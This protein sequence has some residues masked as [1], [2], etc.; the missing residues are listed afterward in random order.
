MYEWMFF[1]HLAGLA[2]WFG[3]TLMGVLML[4]SARKSLAETGVSSIAQ[5]TI[6]NINR[7]SHPSS[8][9]V[10]ASGLYMILQ[11]DRDGLPF[12]ISFMEQAGGT[13]ILLFIVVMSILGSKLRKKLAQAEPAVAARSIGSYAA[14]TS[15]F[16]LAVLVIILIVSLKL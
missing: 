2:V 13:V 6:R 3:V 10:L 12:W 11:L 5:Q 7:L 4:L 16:L 8:F 9:L 15:I 14:W 1:I